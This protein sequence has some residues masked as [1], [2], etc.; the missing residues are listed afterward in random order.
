MH[1]EN[2]DQCSQTCSEVGFRTQALL[3][4]SQSTLPP[5]QTMRWTKVAG[6]EGHFIPTLVLLLSRGQGAVKRQAQQSTFQMYLLS[7]LPLSCG[8]SRPPKNQGRDS[9]IPQFS[10]KLQSKSDW[11]PCHHIPTWPCLP[12][13]WSQISNPI[14]W[15]PLTPMA[16]KL[17]FSFCFC[18]VLHLGLHCDCVCV[19]VCPCQPTPTFCF[20]NEAENKQIHGCVKVLTFLQMK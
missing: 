14:M 10:E 5:R 1:G 19:C 13:S 18:L 16:D 20:L 2:S 17:H 11:E 12:E 4:T 6:P 7:S 3:P 8:F 15:T 9:F